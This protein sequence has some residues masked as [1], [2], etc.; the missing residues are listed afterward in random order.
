[1]PRLP[2]GLLSPGW[3]RFPPGGLAPGV[4]P[5]FGPFPPL[6]FGVSISPGR[7]PPASGPPLNFAYYPAPVGSDPPGFSPQ[8]SRPGAFSLWPPTSAV[9]ASPPVV[10]PLWAPF[11]LLGFNSE[12]ARRK[13]VPPLRWPITPFLFSTP[14]LPPVA[15]NFPPSGLFPVLGL[16][17]PRLLGGGGAPPYRGGLLPVFWVSTSPAPPRGPPKGGPPP[18]PFPP[19]PLT[20]PPGLPRW[21]PPTG[22]LCPGWRFDPPAAS[23]PPGPP[24]PSYYLCWRPVFPQKT[25]LPK[26]WS[27]LGLLSPFFLALP[28]GFPPS[29]G[30]SP[31]AYYRLLGSGFPPGFFPLPR[32]FP[33]LVLP[34]LGVVSPGP[35]SASGPPLGA[36]YPGFFW[37]SNP[38]APF[39]RPF[40]AYGPFSPPLGVSI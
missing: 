3:V 24:L 28:P 2:A 35:P 7:P 5:P 16:T 29:L 21:C 12:N 13:M 33:P 27:S 36:Y 4:V 18:V 20:F 34:P 17:F 38:P 23:R 32:G 14:P 9:F 1:M 39:C 26:K 25:A 31:R 22:L 15:G 37:V 40:P 6:G 19:G 8:G 30:F 11:P 10:P